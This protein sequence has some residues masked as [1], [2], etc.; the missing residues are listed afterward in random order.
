MKTTKTKLRQL[1][2]ANAIAKM[3]VAN[4]AK[5]RDAQ[6][7]FSPIAALPAE[8]A[9]RQ[10]LQALSQ[11][12]FNVFQANLSGKVDKRRYKRLKV[13]PIVMFDEMDMRDTNA[14]N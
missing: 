8:I 7:A 9:A 14:K 10:Q 13:E 4:A 12:P 5:V 11:T 2:K 6:S 1:S 3:V